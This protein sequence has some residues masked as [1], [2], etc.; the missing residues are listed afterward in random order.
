MERLRF[1]TGLL[2]SGEKLFDPP[3]RPGRQR[4]VAHMTQRVDHAPR[5]AVSALA[6]V[7]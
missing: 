4:V 3:F 1:Q 7:D 6:L 5:S 2:E